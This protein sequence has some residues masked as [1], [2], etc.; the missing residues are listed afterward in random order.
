MGQADLLPDAVKKA[1]PQLR[2]QVLDLYGD[3]PLGIVQFSGGLGEA[4]QLGRLEKGG[5]FPEFQDMFL[6]SES[7]KYFKRLF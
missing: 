1:H 4:F 7:F 3:G 5:D 6:P 2:L